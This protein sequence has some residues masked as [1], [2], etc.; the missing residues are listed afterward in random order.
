[1]MN[2][3]YGKEAAKPSVFLDL[4]EDMLDSLPLYRAPASAP[5][6]PPRVGASNSLD[7]VDD[8]MEI[9]VSKKRKREEEEDEI[10]RLLNLDDEDT[11]FLNK[12]IRTPSLPTQPNAL[13][14][15]NNRIV[16][17]NIRPF[18][19]E[20]ADKP[21]NVAAIVAPKLLEPPRPALFEE[22]K[23][24][25]PAPPAAAPKPLVPLAPVVEEKEKDPVVKQMID[26]VLNVV[27][28]AS[29]GYV[30]ELINRLKRSDCLSV[31]F[32]IL[33]LTFFV[34]FSEGKTK[35]DEIP[36]NV[37]NMLLDNPA[38]PKQGQID[39]ATPS[40]LFAAMI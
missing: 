4:T 30:K 1:M 25:P 32:S 2:R 12:F 26:A 8:D 37:I 33:L 35:A 16:N 27:S 34:F 6:A 5:A 17:Q 39:S 28:D 7:L 21:T 23:A 18:V 3:A 22:K 29:F 13:D 40:S 14:N 11:K 10:D 9:I 19:N 20:K 38:Y 24:P 36:P 31:L 15:P